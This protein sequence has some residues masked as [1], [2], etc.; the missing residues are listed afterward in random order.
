MA[1]TNKRGTPY[2]HHV[3]SRRWKYLPS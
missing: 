2:S 1:Y 3:S